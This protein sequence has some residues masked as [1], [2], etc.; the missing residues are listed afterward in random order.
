MIQTYFGLS[1]PPFGEQ[2]IAL[3]PHQQEILDTL[4]VHCRQ[5]GLCLLLGEPGSGKSTIKQALQKHDEKNLIAPVVARSL[6]T[7]LNTLR[8][9][10]EAFGVDYF[11]DVFKCEKSLIEEALRLKRHGKMIAPIIDD[12]HFMPMDCLRRLRLMFEDFPKNHNLILIGQPT[13]M[14]TLSLTVHEDIKSRV[15]YSVLLHKLAPDDL[16][17]FILDQLD[18]AGLGHNAFTEAALALVVRSAQGSIRAA[19][20]LCI[21]ALI[22]AVR[23]QTRTVDIGQVNRVL[24]QPHWR[25]NDDLSQP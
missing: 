19:R 13:L 3:L 2:D 22:E 18:R 1:K 24:I 16:Q 20:N 23:D 21:S 25:A 9:L 7:H 11:T 14:S 12:A 10:C 8:I 15:T 6:H 17:A 4:L 5:G